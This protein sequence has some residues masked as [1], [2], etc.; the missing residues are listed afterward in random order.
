MD[1]ATSHRVCEPKQVFYVEDQAVNVLI[2]EALIRHRPGLRLIVAS[3]GRHALDI[4]P[5]L[6]PSLLLLDLRLPDCH[7]TRLLP[8]LR[9]AE[10][11]GLVPAVAVTA[12]P[13]FEA[14]RTGFLEV[15]HKPL[16]LRFVL[17]RLDRLLAETA[18]PASAASPRLQLHSA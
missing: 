12:E 9:E 17:G 6:K 7:G 5:G 8:Q 14:A 18:V 11:W 2:M 16:D 3:C 10:G 4:A 15:W 13:D 1:A